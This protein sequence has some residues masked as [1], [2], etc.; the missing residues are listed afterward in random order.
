MTFLV[1][2]QVLIVKDLLA[3]K[4]FASPIGGKG[5]FRRNKVIPGWWPSQNAVL[6]KLWDVGVEVRK[7]LPIVQAPPINLVVGIF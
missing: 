7:H 1:E 3:E 5:Q 6:A 2:V 4:N